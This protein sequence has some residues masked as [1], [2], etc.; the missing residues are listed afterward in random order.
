M[1]RSRSFPL[2][3]TLALVA[4]ILLSALPFWLQHH[5]RAAY[6]TT[7]AIALILAVYC[8]AELVARHIAH[9]NLVPTARSMALAGLLAAAL[10]Y[11]A[12]YDLIAAKKSSDTTYLEDL[13]MKDSPIFDQEPTTSE[14]KR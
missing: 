11:V 14:S 6:P 12:P 4:G 3:H 1:S 8:A 9:R 10:L 2:W 13:R 7:R 5:R